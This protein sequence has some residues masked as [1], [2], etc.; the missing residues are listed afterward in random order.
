MQSVLSTIVLGGGRVADYSR[1]NETF[2]SS[3]QIPGTAGQIER[4]WYS[5]TPEDSSL[6]G[7][8]RG[9][10]FIRQYIESYRVPRRMPGYHL[11]GPRRI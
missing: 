5:R 2:P 9:A 8:Y 3:D 11:K 10:T 7:P 6:W 4:T 1:A